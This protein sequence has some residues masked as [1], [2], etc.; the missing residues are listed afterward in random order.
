MKKFWDYL[1][2]MQLA[3]ILLLVLAASM[4][5]ATFLENDFGTLAAQELVYRATWFEILMALFC[6]NLLGTI[7]RKRL[8]QRKKYGAFLFHLSMV[9]ILIGAGI[10]RFISY[11]GTMFIRE[12]KSSNVIYSE[13]PHLQ[14]KVQDGNKSYNFADQQVFSPFSNNEYSNSFRFNNKEVDIEVEGFVPNAIRTVTAVEKGEPVISLVISGGNSGRQNHLLEK[15]EEVSVLEQKVLFS[16]TEIDSSKISFHIK[17][18]DLMIFSPSPLIIMSMADQS[19]DTLPAMNSYPFQPM[20][21]YTLGQVSLVLKQF[22]PNAEVRLSSAGNTANGNAQNALILSLSQGGQSKE[23]IV[24]GGKGMVGEEAMIEL[25]GI[26]YSVSYGSRPIELPFRLELVDFQLER[27]PGSDSPSSYASEVILIDENKGI[28]EPRRIFMN[29]VLNYGGYRFFQSSYDQDEKG[30]ILSVNH[31]YWGTLITYVGYFLLAFGMVYS[32]FSKN[33]RFRFLAKSTSDLKRASGTAGVILLFLTSGIFASQSARAQTQTNPKLTDQYANKAHAERFGKLLVQD[34]DGR[35]EPMNTLASELLR[36][37]ARKNNLN[38][39]TPNQALLGMIINPV[40]WQEIPM[41]KVKNSEVARILGIDGSYAS[42]MDFIDMQSGGTY[43]LQSYV[44]EAYRKKPAERSKFDNEIMKVDERLNISFLV[45]NNSLL[46]IFPIPEDP[47][48]KWVSNQ[49]A[50]SAFNDEAS[51]FVGS[52]LDIYADSV[53]YGIAT[54]NW[55]PANNTL[56]YLFTFQDRYGKELFPS[57]AKLKLEILYNKANIFKRLFQLYGL[58]G[59]IMLIFLFI[60]I[61]RPK[62][63]FG[64]ILNISVWILIIGFLLHTLGLAARWY[65]SGHAPWSNGYESMI[66]IA[67]ATMLAGLIFTK[68]S[69]IAL[70]TTAILSSL[71]LMVAH[72]SWMDPQITN[73]VPVLKSYWLV[74][75][76]AI[77]TASYSFLGLGA[78]LAFFNLILMIS[79][80]KNNFTSLNTKIKELTYIIEMA[81]II[82]VIMLSIGTFLGG[83]WANESWGRY[84]G[85]DPKETWALITIL[86]YSFILH[87]RLIPG[88]RSIFTFNFASLIGFASV[89]MTYFGVNYYLSGLHSYAAGDP[90][91][92]PSF[93]YY[94]VAVVF[95]TGFLAYLK[96]RKFVKPSYY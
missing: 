8:I 73:L 28:R 23:V 64:I 88:L 87:M 35:I 80:T 93:V 81:L 71:I 91:P 6:I 67:W 66:Y 30:T 62:L 53:K 44:E 84:W 17:D 85:W 65:I 56:N 78:L 25:N 86:V 69:R 50:E 95:I 42:F 5:T 34:H 68:R 94:T 14:I 55:E 90:L 7:F 2:S 96:H 11:E 61:L 18:N 39:L 72:L 19:T 36:K 58:I 38:G 27:Y 70:A 60:N 45:Y 89:I 22:Y 76:V 63:K 10:T 26:E 51:V 82:G 15:G 47:T 20:K 31:D 33:S 9:I 13:N 77:I 54:G 52:I 57:Q 21:L 43:K 79:K 41:I 92:V 46:R 29:N 37:V 24:A 32:F 3:G 1:F 59:F 83:V 75:H 12:G 4:A 74:I 16:P 40:K 49:K 48:H